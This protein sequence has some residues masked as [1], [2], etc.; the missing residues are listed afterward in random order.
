VQTLLGHANNDILGEPAFKL[1]SGQD[2]RGYENDR[3]AGNTML[4]TNIEY[5]FPHDDYPIIRYVGFVD[6]GNTYD[7]IA[8]I[9]HQS[10]N[11]GVGVGLRWK[12]RAFVNLDLRAD[13]GYGITDSDYK[14]SFGTSNAF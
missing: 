10:L 9:F 7:E 14:F 4:L 6:L 12:L 13:F 5:M 11:F 8:D 2:L 3:F 1:G